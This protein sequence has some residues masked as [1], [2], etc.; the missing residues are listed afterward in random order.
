MKT[1]EFNPS[2]EIIIEVYENGVFHV[3]GKVI[4]MD[5]IDRGLCWH[6]ANWGCWLG[7]EPETISGG[8]Y[9][10]C[11]YVEDEGCTYV[12]L[13][14]KYDHC[15]ENI[16]IRKH[17]DDKGYYIVSDRK[18]NHDQWMCGTSREA[19]AAMRRNPFLR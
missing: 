19:V 13:N 17:Y 3:A 8:V 15:N 9:N 10:G 14:P 1:V 5:D 2:K 18:R 11:K 12:I 6:L 7:V 16:F 4:G